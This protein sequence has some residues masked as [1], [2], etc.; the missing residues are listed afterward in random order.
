VLHAGMRAN[1]WGL[2]EEWLHR[3]LGRISSSDVISGIPGSHA[4]HHDAPYQ[5][6]EEFVS[7]YRLHPLLPDELE[8]HSL[9]DHELLEVLPF[10]DIILMNAERVLASGVKAADLWYSFGVQNPGAVCL[11]N[12]PR[13]LQDLTLPDG[14]RL[15]LGAVDIIRDRERGVPR[16]NQF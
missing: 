4:D 11:H 7:V 5:I 2:A 16:Y 6:T 10:K 1:W 15:D 3:H 9:K 8:V 12:F 14:I 13:F